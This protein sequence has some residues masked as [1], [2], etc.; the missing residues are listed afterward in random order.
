MEEFYSFMETKANFTDFG[1][2]TEKD[3]IIKIL[4]DEIYLSHTFDRSLSAKNLTR[5]LTFL[6]DQ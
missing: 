5:V 1:K 3:Q 4:E 6:K 2:G